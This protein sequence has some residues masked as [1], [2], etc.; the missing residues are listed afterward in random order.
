MRRAVLALALAAAA[1]AAVGATGV[2]A[3]ASTTIYATPH[4]GSSAGQKVTFTASF[5]FACGDQVNTH[6]FVVDKEAFSST[7]T[8]AGH[9]AVE[10]LS[11][12][13]LA[14]GRHAVSYHWDTTG[15]SGQTCQGGAS[16]YYTVTAAPAQAATP[17]APPLAASPVAATPS[18][19]F[20]NDVA[21]AGVRPKNAPPPAG[22]PN[23][24]YLALALIGLAVWAGVGLVAL[25]R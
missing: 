21:A 1:V 7:L 4:N 6:Y 18:P 2:S 11:V 22:D 12:S 24:G 8:Q 10:T 16:L 20:A 23:Y 15:A 17:S 13:T 14:P 19:R 3:D 9:H 25:R 5:T